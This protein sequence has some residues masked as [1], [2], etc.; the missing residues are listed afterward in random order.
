[1]NSSV[2]NGAHIECK[3]RV[4]ARIQTHEGNGRIEPDNN[5][6]I[7]LDGNSKN[8]G[9]RIGDGRIEAQVYATVRKDPRE[10]MAV[11]AVVRIKKSAD[12]YLAVRLDRDGVNRF[13]RAAI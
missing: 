12:Q 11:S 1:M 3:I 7:G 2:R 5:L 4:A 13:V 10:P 6:A 8:I 9:H